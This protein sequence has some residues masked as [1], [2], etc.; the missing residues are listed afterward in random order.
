MAE[1]IDLIL[2][3]R[4][5]IYFSHV[6]W[7]RIRGRCPAGKSLSQKN[8]KNPLFDRMKY[9]LVISGVRISANPKIPLATEPMN[10]AYP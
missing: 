8:A 10:A 2:A 9:L 4:E 7:T 5:A 1:F 3:D 6:G